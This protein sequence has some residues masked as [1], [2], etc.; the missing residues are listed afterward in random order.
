M[1]NELLTCAL[2]HAED[3]INS[4]LPQWVTIEC[5]FDNLVTLDWGWITSYG[6]RERSIQTIEFEHHSLTGDILVARYT[7]S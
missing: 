5:K 3:I 7:H 4:P 2:A 6:D 1:N